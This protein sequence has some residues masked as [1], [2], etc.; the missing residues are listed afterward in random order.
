MKSIIVILAGLWT[1]WRYT[2]LYSDQ[3]L[4]NMIAPLG[5]FIFLIS[6][7]LWLLLMTPLGGRAGRADGYGSDSSD[8][9]GDS[10]GGDGGGD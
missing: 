6:L 9:G 10:W 7:L 2:D 8:F 4:F 5:V 3:T 1:S